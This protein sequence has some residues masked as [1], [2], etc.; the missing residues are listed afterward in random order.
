MTE[1]EKAEIKRDEFNEL[2]K[3]STIA[4]REQRKRMKS[5]ELNSQQEMLLKKLIVFEAIEN[6]KN[7]DPEL[8]YNMYNLFFDIK[9]KVKQ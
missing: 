2:N 8:K 7:E 4:L 3:A 6:S 9:D 1:E 5:M